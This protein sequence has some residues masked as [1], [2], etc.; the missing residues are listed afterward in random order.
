MSG[1]I[2]FCAAGCG[3]LSLFAAGWARRRLRCWFYSALEYSQAFLLERSA[4]FPF[5]FPLSPALW[6][7]G[8][9]D[10][11]RIRLLSV[12]LCGL[13][14][15]PVSLALLAFKGARASLC[16]A[17]VF[18]LPQIILMIIQL[19]SR[20][21]GTDGKLHERFN[22]YA[23]LSAADRKKTSAQANKT[24]VTALGRRFFPRKTGNILPQDNTLRDEALLK[25]LSEW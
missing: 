11:H 22:R 1:W 15:L 18:L 4:R 17:G 19:F 10:A 9:F 3:L 23:P 2:P 25:R 16:C 20:V 7:S 6:V 21:R 24:T 8:Y 14:N 12:L 13:L 5:R